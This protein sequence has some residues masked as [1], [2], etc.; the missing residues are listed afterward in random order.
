M[1]GKRFFNLLLPT[2]VVLLGTK[3]TLCEASSTGFAYVTTN[4][5]RFVL[6]GNSVYLNGFNAYWLMY[7]ASFPA[8]RDNITA[9]F[10]LAAKSKMNVLRTWAF[11]DGVERALQTS[12]GVY[13][14][15]MFE[16]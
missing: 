1:S 9:T 11:S 13:N 14:E 2:L 16:V 3:G 8:N 15:E 4:G 10:Q 12:P 5:T 7:M 6:N